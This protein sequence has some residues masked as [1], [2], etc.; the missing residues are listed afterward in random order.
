[1]TYIL[2]FFGAIIIFALVN[3]LKGLSVK[4]TEKEKKEKE[5]AFKIFK[6]K[7]KINN[8]VLYQY[9]VPKGTHTERF[10]SIYYN[11]DYKNEEKMKE[12]L[13]KQS[14]SSIYKSKKEKKIIRINEDKLKDIGVISHYEGKPFSGVTFSLYDNNKIKDEISFKSGL[15]HGIAKIFYKNGQLKYETEYKNDKPV[16]ALRA[17]TE[18]GKK[19]RLKNS[20]EK[21]RKRLTYILRSGKD[22]EKETEIE[23][24]SSM[25]GFADEFY[26]LSDWKQLEILIET[27]KKTN[28]DKGFGTWVMNEFRFMEYSFKNE[29]KLKFAEQI[30]KYY[31]ND[32]SMKELKEYFDNNVTWKKTEADGELI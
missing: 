24:F 19:I 10:E 22:G 3:Y 32:L 9:T 1:M 18:D 31:R 12:F 29:F 21:S 11:I 15:K 25:L 28:N 6:E 30:M 23:T 27:L 2:I 8:K 14:Y 13:L 20:T 26:E 16:K 5:K 7:Y 17:Y 4:R